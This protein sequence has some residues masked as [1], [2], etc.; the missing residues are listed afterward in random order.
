MIF[1]ASLAIVSKKALG[2][3]CFQTSI[4]KI[5]DTLPID[6]EVSGMDAVILGPRDAVGPTGMKLQKA[7]KEAHANVCI[8][9]VYNKE[10]DK[11]LVSC[12]YKKL[13]KKTTEAVIADVQEE[14]LGDHI[15]KIGKQ[16]I[17]RKDL[18][19]ST[20]QSK[21]EIPEAYTEPKEEEELPV[22]QPVLEVPAEPEPLPEPEQPIE[23][24]QSVSHIEDT[25]KAITNYKDWNLFMEQMNKDN[26][27]RKLIEENTEYVGLV[28]MLEVLDKQIETV[29]RDTALS[30]ERKFEK[31]KEIGLSRSN[32]RG[33]SNSINVTKVLSIIETIC[34]SAKRT[35]EEKLTTVREAMVKITTDKESIM[36]TSHIDNAIEERTNIQIELMDIMRGVIDL[37][38][39]MDLL[40]TEEIK[41]LDA[42][43]P[44]DNMFVN[45][46]VK[47]VGTTIFTP[48]NTAELATKLMQALQ[49]H[50][51]T[52]SQLEASI[53]NTISLIFQ[54]CEKDNEIIQYQQNMIN[55][56]KANRIEDIVL[57][58][59]LLKNVLHVYTGTDET[60][61]SATAI[62]WSGICSRKQNTLLID[63]TGRDK[64]ATYGIDAYDLD[65]FFEKSIEDHFVCV[66]SAKLDPEDLQELIHK[67]KSFLNYYPII[68]IIVAPED[69]STIDQ[70][71][72]DALTIS[73]ITDCSTR[74]VNQMKEVISKN[75][76]VNIAHKLIL[77]DAP[78]SPLM[79]AD[80]M[81]IDP[82]TTKLITLP[83]INAIKACSLK[84]DRPYEYDSIVRIFEEAFH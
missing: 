31:I 23:L 44:S 19:E 55:L 49:D 67:L 37:Y 71:C 75:D 83:N 40:I 63:M 32:L 42:R 24:P 35:V 18:E 5:I 53:K 9:Y 62:T 48:V 59:S 34:L 25:L 66:R 38:K 52:M 39:S 33:Q 10:R 57:R 6:P 7:I 78:V 13:V 26:I 16:Q 36:D 56:L 60:G 80:M 84:N 28:N 50:R 74:S 68:N 43:L 17:N 8:I 58:D 21:S 46:M 3:K 1:A 47:P 54:L 72:E 76:V 82:T 11:D 51:L 12:Q 14:F 29:W 41:D 45:E 4:N 73:Y 69:E 20:I 27:T 22:E 30:P 64:F 61:R 70:L 2:D 81:K 79:M 65:E 77:I 15:I